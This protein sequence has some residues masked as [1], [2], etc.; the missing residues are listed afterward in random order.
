MIWEGFMEELGL[1]MI[2]P[3]GE[4]EWERKIKQKELHV[5]RPRGE[6]LGTFGDI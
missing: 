4:R 2:T 1:E 6:T 5:K 3:E